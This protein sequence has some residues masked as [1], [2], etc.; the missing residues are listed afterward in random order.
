MLTKSVLVALRGLSG[1]KLTAAMR[2]RNGEKS[3]PAGVGFQWVSEGHIGELAGSETESGRF[4]EVHGHCAFRNFHSTY[5]PGRFIRHQNLFG[6]VAVIPLS[7]GCTF[8]GYAPCRV[9]AHFCPSEP[10]AVW[11]SGIWPGRQKPN[12]LFP[13]VPIW[14]CAK[15]ARSF[16]ERSPEQSGDLVRR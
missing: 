8:G 5:H 10:P 6:S 12:Y 15:Q 1:R 2:G 16:Q 11:P 7:A 9:T 3:S 4:L 13:L 14:P